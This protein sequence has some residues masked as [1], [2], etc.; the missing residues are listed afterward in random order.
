MTGIQKALIGSAGTLLMAFVVFGIYP[1]VR[2]I[3][4]IP[5]SS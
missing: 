4:V 1:W 5:Y 2:V 3:E